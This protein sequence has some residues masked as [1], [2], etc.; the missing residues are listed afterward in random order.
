VKEQHA[1]GT[2]SVV[3]RSAGGVAAWRSV[4]IQESQSDG[5]QMLAGKSSSQHPNDDRVRVRASHSTLAYVLRLLMLTGRGGVPPVTREVPIQSTSV[6]DVTHRMK[7]QH[8]GTQYTVC[9]T[10]ECY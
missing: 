10:G 5:S 7:E 8:G 6:T 3:L 4:H 1:H 2:R 9:G